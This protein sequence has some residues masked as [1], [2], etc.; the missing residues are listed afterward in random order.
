MRTELSDLS[1]N[2]DAVKALADHLSKAAAKAQRFPDH[3]DVTL[4]DCRMTSARLVR[5]I[6]KLN[7]CLEALGCPELSVMR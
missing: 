5:R 6:G 3:N 7:M 2:A 1:H 4:R